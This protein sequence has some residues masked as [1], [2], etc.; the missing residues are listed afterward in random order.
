MVLNIQKCCSKVSLD[1]AF[2]TSKPRRNGHHC[3]DVISEC[4]FMKENGHN[5]I[6]I[7]ILL[8]FVPRGPINNMPALVQMMAWYQIG[9]KSLSQ[10][11]NDNIFY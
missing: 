11:C 8:K 7:K 4:I 2:Y 9:E 10:P 3:T 5:V 6:S 1:L